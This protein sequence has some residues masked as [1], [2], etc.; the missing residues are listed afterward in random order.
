M[1]NNLINW[2]NGKKTVFGAIIFFIVALSTKI[3]EEFGITVDWIQPAL[4]VLE[5]IAMALTTVGLG[6]KA[7]KK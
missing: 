6:H 2:F 3:V 1:I 4:N 7:I 5:Y